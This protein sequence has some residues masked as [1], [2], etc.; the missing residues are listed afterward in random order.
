MQDGYAAGASSNG[1]TSSEKAYGVHYPTA[2]RGRR[3]TLPLDFICIGHFVP[4][5]TTSRQTKLDD[6]QE[7]AVILISWGREILP[8]RR[9]Q[10]E[11]Q[12]RENRGFTK[13]PQYRPRSSS[14]P[15]IPRCCWRKV[16]TARVRMHGRQIGCPPHSTVTT[17]LRRRPP[18][19][20]DATSSSA[21]VGWRI[22]LAFPTRNVHNDD[23]SYNWRI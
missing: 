3:N 9:S 20:P 1:I 17:K 15:R 2:R 5:A 18:T 21:R 10:G 23:I 11:G 19:S 14:P 13:L 22:P 7:P 6:P 12:V 4:W 8:N 16:V